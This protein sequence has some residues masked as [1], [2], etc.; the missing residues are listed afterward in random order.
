M[1]Q[2]II[3]N[4]PSKCVRYSCG[5][6][7]EQHSLLSSPATWPSGSG[8][9]WKV[10]PVG[11]HFDADLTENS[12]PKTLTQNLNPAIDAAIRGENPCEHLL[13]TSTLT[14]VCFTRILVTLSLP[15]IMK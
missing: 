2:K 5:H 11:K 4:L 8:F 7:V 15:K 1:L 3:H 6:C 14:E 10:G 12:N 9:C 13:L